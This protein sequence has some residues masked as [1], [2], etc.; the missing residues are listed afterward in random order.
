MRVCMCDAKGGGGI[1]R[2]GSPSYVFYV[3]RLPFTIHMHDPLT[4]SHSQASRTRGRWRW[5]ACASSSCSPRW[6]CWQVRLEE[7]HASDVRLLGSSS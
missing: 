3:R 1:G 4:D 6:R 2:I 5:W 7:T